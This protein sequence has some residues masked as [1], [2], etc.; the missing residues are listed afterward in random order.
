MAFLWLPTGK[1]YHLQRSK[2]VKACQ[3]YIHLDDSVSSI[4]LRI[5]NDLAMLKPNVFAYVVVLLPLAV[6]LPTSPFQLL[7]LPHKYQLYQLYQLHETSHHI[8]LYK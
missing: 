5:Q 3:S 6:A 1:G 8:L 4:H 7:N 2:H